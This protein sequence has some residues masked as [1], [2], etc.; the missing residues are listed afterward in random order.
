[1]NEARRFVLV[2][3]VTV[4]RCERRNEGT[5]ANSWS[6]YLSIRFGLCAFEEVDVP[7]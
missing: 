7:S 4:S 5:V 3:F 1:M 6:V 2:S